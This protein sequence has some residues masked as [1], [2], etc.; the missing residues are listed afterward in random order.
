MKGSYVFNKRNHA[1]KK[2]K[3]D[4]LF[5]LCV[6]IP[7]VLAI[8]YFSFMASD[9]YTSESSFIIR[10]PE[11][12]SSSGGLSLILRSAGF[13]R[14]QDD[15]YA[16]DTFIASRDALQQLQKTLLIKEKYSSEDID[17]LNRFGT[18]L[19]GNSFE[20]LYKYYQNK[21]TVKTDVGTAITK[22]TV[23]AYTPESAYQINEKLLSLSESLVNNI[24]NNARK[25]L[26]TF[27]ETEMTKAEEQANRAMQ[28]LT[29][30]RN[31][32]RVFNPEGQSTQVL[33]Q[34]TK[35]QD[36]LVQTKL[37]L[38]Q[39]QSVAPD[40]SQIQPLQIQIKV[41]EKE[42]QSQ[43]SNVVGDKQSF[44]SQ[45]GNFQRLTL[46]KELADKQLIAAMTSLEQARND[47][48]RKQL[49]LERVAQPSLPDA[50]LEPK[51]LKGIL[52]TLLLGL[53]VWG[54][55]SMLMAGAREHKN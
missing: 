35:L 44:T 31:R 43:K 18:S 22:L 29:N 51:R 49:Y 6:L 19:K 8:V 17:Y 33:T 11:R 28:A 37:Q 50:A 34:I 54:I 48:V 15:S 40:N 3:I 20:G 14:A 2:L 4:L 24:N 42:I 26:I 12:Q 1:L 45:S 5:V 32:N 21:I 47:A 7:S 23:K 41:L 25:D 30:Y 9:I 38:A 16:V 13:S 53:I 46:E 55:L 10:S 27:A 39:I 52:A 36:Q